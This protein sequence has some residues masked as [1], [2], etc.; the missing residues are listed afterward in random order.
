MILFGKHTKINA[1]HSAM[2]SVFEIEIELTSS[3]GKLQI[4]SMQKN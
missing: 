2:S 1:N 4:E 3:E